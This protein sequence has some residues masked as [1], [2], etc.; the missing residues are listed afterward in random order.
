MNRFIEVSA[1]KDVLEA[2]ESAIALPQYTS[3]VTSDPGMGKSW[4]LKHYAEKLGAKYIEIQVAQKAAAAMT[5][6]LLLLYQ[7]WV[8]GQPTHATV[9][10]SLMVK[11]EAIGDWDLSGRQPKL[12][13]VDEFQELEATALRDLQ[14]ICEGSGTSLVLSGNKERLAKERRE[15]RPALDQIWSRVGHRVTLAPPSS[16]DCRDIAISHNVEG[17]ECYDALAWFGG[18]TSLRDLCKLLDR[19]RLVAGPS[20]TIRLPH[21][22]A[23]LLALRGSRDALKLLSPPKNK[24]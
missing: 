11:M 20:G 14:K 9:R 23:A 21:V 3:L 6:A 10:D 12:L 8:R 18:Q 4:A 17:K 15:D 5:R 2:A 19:A 7:G 24:N 13:F 16:T 1:A 22:E